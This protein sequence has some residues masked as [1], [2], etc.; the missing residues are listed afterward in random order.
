MKRKLLL[1]LAGFAWFSSQGQLVNDGAT[2]VIQPGA[3]LF[4]ESNFENVSGTLN[5]QGTMEV[6]GNFTNDA[7]SNITNAGTIKFTGS[8]LSTV[9][10]SG[11]TLNNVEVN[12]TSAL[13]NVALGGPMTIKGSL[14]FN[15]ANTGKIVLG[16]HDLVLVTG[17]STTGASLTTGHVN[18]S[19]NGKM[20]KQFLAP[21]LFNFPVG[22]D[23]EFSP[24][25]WTP[26]VGASGAGNV[27]VSVVDETHPNKPAIITTD[28]LSR[29]WKVTSTTY[30]SALKG[31]FTLADVNGTASKIKGASFTSPNTWTYAGAANGVNSVSG[32]SNAGTFDFTGIATIGSLKLKTWLAG[33]YFASGDTMSTQLKIKNL[34]PN[35]SPY[36]E[37][38]S[39][40]TPPANATDWVLLELKDQDNGSNPSIFK[41]AFILKDGTI[42]DNSG[43]GDPQILGAY[44]NSIVTI[45]HR[46][47]FAIRVKLSLNTVSPIFTPLTDT[48]NVLANSSITTNH[49]MQLLE[50]GV[51]GMWG[52]NTNSDLFV[53]YS[54]TSNDQDVIR[55]EILGFPSNSFNSL[56]YSILNTYRK[57]D[58]NLDGILRFSGSNNDSD[59]IR[60]IILG[61]PRNTFNSL[62]ST[63]NAHF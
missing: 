37:D 51:W 55:N 1:L 36:V 22:D 12:K 25:E 7:G 59:V 27:S 40:G 14:T 15:G 6:M 39:M 33:A 21:V 61:N 13:G 35:T 63:V 45:R 44:A 46:N 41:S 29:Y 16:D 3:T 19:G 2:I 48:L 42:V 54:G 62:T 43:S 4:V 56:T 30:P 28:Y 17:A 20:T 53:R 60:N 10:M 34:I 50:P 38:P 8:G 58:V 23:N 52:G 11:D 49:S 24:L 57:S 26:G 5:N 47:H 9:V 18:A 32:N 31:T